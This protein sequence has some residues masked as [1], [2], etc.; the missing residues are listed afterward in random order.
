M[1]L[2]KAGL[3]QTPVTLREGGSECRKWMDGSIGL[4]WC[5]FSSF[6]Q[7]SSKKKSGGL[8]LP[9]DGGGVTGGGT[10]KRG[11]HMTAAQAGSGQRH[12]PV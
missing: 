3:Q 11:G 7:L 1:A 12:L 5:F 2:T 6:S 10:D 4:N 8:S 9:I